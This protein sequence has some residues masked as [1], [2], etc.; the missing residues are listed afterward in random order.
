MLIPHYLSVQVLSQSD[1]LMINKMCSSSDAGIY[2][3]AYTFAMLLQL[4]TSAISTSFTP[5]VYQKI[6]RKEYEKVKAVTTPIV[7]IVSLL[8]LA[9]IC[10]IPDIFFVLLPQS[11]HPAIWVIPPV[12]V[13]AFFMFLYPLFGSVEFYFNGNRFVTAASIIGA[14]LNLL[15]NYIFIPIFGFIAAAYTTLFCYIFFSVF[16]YVS[17]VWLLR[18]NN[19][20]ERIYGIG[21]ITAISILTIVL[22]VLITLSY[23]NLYIRYAI[24]LIA[25]LCGIYFREK[26]HLLFKTITNK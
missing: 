21:Q 9:L 17:M 8:T 15:L 4:V 16:H 13:G 23:S 19:I 20:H 3:I 7:L 24:V 11:Y 25:V 26:I 12:A 1:R 18:K 2:S 14:S 22:M 6:N 10:V 5:W